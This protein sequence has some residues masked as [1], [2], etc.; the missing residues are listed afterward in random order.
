MATVTRGDR[1]VVYVT[2]HGRYAREFSPGRFTT[3]D[4][5]ADASVLRNIDKSAAQTS[6]GC[7]LYPRRVRVTVTITET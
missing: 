7:T 6:L 4:N 3:V 1:G 2:K 5:L